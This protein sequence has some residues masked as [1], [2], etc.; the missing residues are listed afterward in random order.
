MLAL[1]DTFE[2][3]FTTYGNINVANFGVGKYVRT[4]ELVCKDN[5]EK[6]RKH[7]EDRYVGINCI[8][9]RNERRRKERGKITVYKMNTMSRRSNTYDFNCTTKQPRR[10]A[11][12]QKLETI[13]RFL[14]Y[15]QL[16]LGA[17]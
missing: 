2:L 3:F 4:C 15:V 11:L 9:L 8:I 17:Y 5:V 1:V 6:E 16:L 12:Q 10:R 13:A 14:S 7:R